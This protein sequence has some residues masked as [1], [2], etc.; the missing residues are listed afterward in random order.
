L[1]SDILQLMLLHPLCPLV[2]AC[3]FANEPF[4]SH[5]LIVH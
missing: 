4:L 5:R 1:D 2:V 3:K